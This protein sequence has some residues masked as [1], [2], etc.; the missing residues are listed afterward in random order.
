[1]NKIDQWD[2]LPLKFHMHFEKKFAAWKPFL[3]LCQ[4][5][6]GASTLP[7][8]FLQDQPRDPIRFV[9]PISKSIWTVDLTI[10]FC[11]KIDF[12]H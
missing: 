5:F 9:D 11:L 10:D 6:V 8:F 12:P 4:T 7:N 3:H 1:M 2:L